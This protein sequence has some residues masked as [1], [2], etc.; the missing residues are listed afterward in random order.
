MVEGNVLQDA[1]F[2][3]VVPHFM[4]QFGIPANATEAAKWR[5]QRIQDDPVKQSNTRG[6][7]T[8]ATSGPNSRTTQMFINFGDNSF[9][10]KQGF[11]PFGEVLGEGMELVDMIQSKYGES[12]NQG[13]IQSEGNAYLDEEFPGLSSINGVTSVALASNSGSHN[14]HHVAL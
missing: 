5:Q 1:R 14:D 11:S 8:F 3:R 10:D 9:L 7:I 12:P 6:R 2:F 13:M 4:A